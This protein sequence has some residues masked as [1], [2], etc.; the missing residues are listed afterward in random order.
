MPL[1]IYS[2]WLYGEMMI[3]RKYS[4]DHNNCSARKGHPHVSWFLHINS[5]EDYRVKYRSGVFLFQ[6]L[7]EL[8]YYGFL[9]SCS[10]HVA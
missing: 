9:S 4:D 5:N 3:R 10:Q 1:L 6:F 8:D 2:V 7:I